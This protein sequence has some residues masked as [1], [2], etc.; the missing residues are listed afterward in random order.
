MLA[1]LSVWSKVR[2]ICIWSIWCHCHPIISC[3]SKIQNALSFWCQLT[4]VVLEKRPLNGWSSSGSDDDECS[5]SHCHC[6]CCCCVLTLLSWTHYFAHGK[7]AKYCDHHLCVSVH[8]HVTEATLAN[9]TK[10]PLHCTCGR[11][12]VLLWRQC[13][14]LCTSGFLDAVMFSRNA[15]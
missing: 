15:T 14:M 4:Q 2:M 5:S 7:D 9:F 11:G 8:S 12:S 10:F 13:T 1:W 3:S 6:C